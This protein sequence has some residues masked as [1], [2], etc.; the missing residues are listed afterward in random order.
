MDT[1]EARTLTATTAVMCRMPACP[2]TRGPL[3]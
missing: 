3:A 2:A 1:R